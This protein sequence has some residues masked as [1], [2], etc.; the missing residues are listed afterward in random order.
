MF[1]NV[2]DSY[3]GLMADVTCQL[4]NPS[5][6][7]KRAYAG[8]TAVGALIGCM[9]AAMAANSLTGSM[10]SLFSEGFN[11]LIVLANGYFILTIVMDIMRYRSSDP[12]K[13]RTGKDGLIRGVICLIGVNMVGV[14]IK[15]VI[16]AAGS[17][18]SGLGDQTS[19]TF[20]N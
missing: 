18:N 6:K 14:L 17:G 9:Q 12:Q 13:S 19:G 15:A 1:K 16:N 8:A 10:N 7:D 20:G 3:Y 5:K 11:L 2:K 4:M